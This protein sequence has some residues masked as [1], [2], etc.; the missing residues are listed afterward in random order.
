[1]SAL[2]TEFACLD[3]GSN[4]N[5]GSVDG[6]TTE[7]SKNALVEYVGGSWT[8]ATDVFVAPVGSDMTQAVVGRF[9]ALFHDGDTAPTTNQ[10]LVARI[11]TVVVGTRSITLSTSARCLLGT[12]VVDGA[13][14]RS[15]RIGGA[16]LG[17]NGINNFPFGFITTSLTNVAGSRV[18]VNFRTDQQYNITATITHANQT[19]VFDG[20]DV[21]YHDGGKFIIDGGV[22]GAA[23]TLLNLSGTG[24]IL[25]NCIVQN[26]GASVGT[27]TFGITGS[28]RNLAIGC[29]ARHLRGHGIN[30][31]SVECEAWDCNQSNT[32]L[33]GGFHQGSHLRANSHHNLG[34]NS[35]GFSA[36]GTLIDCISAENGSHGAGNFTN[37]FNIFKGVDFYFNGGNGINGVGGAG[38]NIESCNFVRNG[39]A[40]LATASNGEGVFAN[41]AFG[42]GTMANTGGTGLTGSPTLIEIGTITLAADTTPW[43]DPDNGDFRVNGSQ[44]VGAGRG[45]FTNTKVSY[46]GTVGYPDVGAAQHIDLTQAAVTDVRD[47][48]VYANGTLVGVLTLPPISKVR[49]LF[50][51]GANGTEFTGEDVLPIEGDVRDTVNYGFE[52]G[53]V[54]EFT[55]SLN[56]SCDYP[57]ENDV[58]EGILY[59]SGTMTG[60][61]V[62]PIPPTVFIGTLYGASGSEFVG[63]FSCPPAILIPPVATATTS[64]L[65]S[66][67]SSKFI[68]GVA[69]QGINPW[70]LMGIIQEYIVLVTSLDIRSVRLWL[71]STRPHLSGSDYYIWFR[72]LSDKPS[73]SIG[74]GRWGNRSDLQIEI[75]VL[76]RNFADTAQIDERRSKAFYELYWKLE[77]AFQGRNLFTKYIL[78]TITSIWHPP[79]A[80]KG[81]GPLTIEP[82]YLQDL[83]VPD[84]TQK[85]EGTL[86]AAF[87]VVLPVVLALTVP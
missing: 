44:N 84:K 60:N 8:A 9:A 81:V 52:N 71:S 22:S 75:H 14:N 72:P 74:P 82:M 58:R 65:K 19:F 57:I 63:T 31:S 45:V 51:Y 33:Q 7:P 29:I 54:W 86:E 25:R 50:T 17:P 56:V 68:P 34:S 36:P 79:E 59:A 16:W 26:N 24:G 15:L 78:S 48:V 49:E 46:T 20:Y 37:V 3:Q 80:G 42:S 40:A 43:V 21:A 66:D 23:Y 73:K 1:M 28:S 87:V 64:L 13:A 6:S 69:N 38:V 53:V 11:T 18:A 12:E 10:Y 70:T 67:V 4:L 2:F 47:G 55:G 27:G 77:Q 32:A 30:V 61:I 5:A 62:L 39:A 41:N 35:I 83:P 85:E 76:A